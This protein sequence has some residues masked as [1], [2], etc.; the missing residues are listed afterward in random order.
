[1]KIGFIGTG[2]LGLPVSLMYNEKGHEL[3][4]Y[5]VNEQFYTNTLP[6][7][8]L[9][10]EELCPEN[11]IKLKDWLQT[12]RFDL[13][14][15]KHT[16][17]ETIV[18]N[19][20]IIFLAVQTPHDKDYEGISRLPSTRKDFDYSYLVN[21]IQQLSEVADKKQKHIITVIISTVLPGTIRQYI[22]PIKSS[23]IN[24]C[25]NPYFIAMGTVAYDCTH[26]E[27][28]LLGSDNN[29]NTIKTVKSFYSTITDSLI[30]FTSIENA[31]MIKV[32]YNTFISTKIAM[33]NTIMELCH[34]CPNTDCDDV[35]DALSK[36]TQRLISPAYLRGGMGDGGG[37]H[38]R[39]NIALSWLSNKVNMK[40]N[41]F[42]SIMTAREKQTEFLADIIENEHKQ[43]GLPVIILGTSFKPNTAIKT[44][45]PAILLTNILKE[46]NINFEIYDPV[47]SK[48]EYEY[49]S[50]I[51]F[52]GCAHSTIQ[53]I[54]IPDGSVVI[55]PHRKYS[56]I[57]SNSKY[58]PVGINNLKV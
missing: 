3:F 38:P 7:D 58:I 1:M 44:G 51:Y 28:I 40:F 11:N 32:C 57:I 47:S 54:K 21:S 56:K 30:H 6:Y 17:L 52:I 9:Y 29:D 14:K 2:K 53:L 13:S 15:Y 27:F 5:D 45:S 48:E 23:Y 16:D 34:Y 37:C 8:L 24:I 42:D 46:R 12:S 36:G 33:A 19:S 31:E 4:C 20:D 26:P 55:D 35:I 18:D 43:S 39:D 49:K 50:G 22:L 41:W 10:D 25:Y